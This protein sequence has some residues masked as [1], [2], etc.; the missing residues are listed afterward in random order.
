MANYE[1]YYETLSESMS[2]QE[3]GRGKIEYFPTNSVL[4]IIS[5]YLIVKL[6]AIIIKK[7]YQG[8]ISLKWNINAL[9]T[10][11]VKGAQILESGVLYAAYTSEH[12]P[13]L[14]NSSFERGWYRNKDLDFLSSEDEYTFH[15]EQYFDFLEMLIKLAQNKD[16]RFSFSTH[17]IREKYNKTK[18]ENISFLYS[19]ENKLIKFLRPE[20]LDKNYNINED[21]KIEDIIENSD[22]IELEPPIFIAE[23][24]V[25]KS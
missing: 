24:G 21:L 8:K 17:H 15:F 2:F 5:Y 23:Y 1:Y 20:I 6:P 22:K 13:L 11:I 3:I 9:K 10:N 19:F 25:R 16:T 12:F 4:D 7:E 18:G 14:S